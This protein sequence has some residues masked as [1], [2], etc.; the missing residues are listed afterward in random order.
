[1]RRPNV[2][3]SEHRPDRIA[4]ALG[5]VPENSPD[6]SGEETRGVLHERDDGS[7]IANDSVVLA[8]ESGLRAVDALTLP[9]G[10]DVGAG[11]SANDEIHRSTPRAS[12]EGSHVRPDRSVVQGPVANARDQ[13]RGGCDFVLH[14]ADRAS[15][16]A[17]RG[18][19]AEVETPDA[20]EEG[21]H[22]DGT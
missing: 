3:R 13:A 4:N 20:G 8:P 5:Q 1:M 16:T 21:Q 6:S 17:Q 2:G 10:R 12:V 15:S 19:D 22:P 18:A 7:Q 11:E 14:V 9:R